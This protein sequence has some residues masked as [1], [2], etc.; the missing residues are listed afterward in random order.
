MWT[1][2]G[3]EQ[4]WTL[5]GGFEA[6]VRAV[7][8][9]VALEDVDGA[10]TTYRELN[11]QANR[12][13]RLLVGRGVG[14]EVR[15]ALVLERSPAQVVAIL[16][17]LK[18]GG[19]Y[20]PIDAGYPPERIALMHADSGASLVLTTSDLAAG[21]PSGTGPL[22]S[23]DEPGTVAALAAHA[24]GNL[25]LELWGDQAVYVI[26]TSGSTGT[27]KGVVVSNANLATL[28]V[29]AQRILR[30][31]PSDVWTLFHSCSFDFAVWEQF[32]ALLH[33]G[34]LVLVSREQA[35]S[36]EEYL[37]LVERAGVT[38]FNQTPSAFLQFVQTADGLG[39]TGWTDP[40]RVVFL[41]GES[42]EAA[43]LAGWYGREPASRPM[44]TNA[45][46]ATEVSILN[47]I[48]LMDPASAAAGAGSLIGTGLPGLGVTVLDAG[49]APVPPGG[50]GEVHV[51]GP[52]VTRGYH[53]RPGLTAR[54]FV[55]DPAGPAGSRMYRTGD[56]A[57]WAGDELEFLGR[58]DDQVK[59]RGFRIELG[60]VEAAIATCPA[61]AQ[62][63]VAAREDRP[64]DQVLVAYV[65][66]DGE[67]AGL[68][69]AV[70]AWSSARLPAHMVPAT[71]LVLPA[72]PLTP[73]GKLDRKAL[74]A[75]PVH[76]AA[77]DGTETGTERAV[78]AIWAQLLGRDG[79]TRLDDFL[80]LGGHSLVAARIAARVRAEL[81]TGVQVRDFY[82]YPRLADFACRVEALQVPAAGT[83]ESE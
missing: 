77:G 41:G 19:A 68:P 1:D 11:A 45:Y 58:A 31:G 55:P 82:D 46:G 63:A 6:Q 59:I 71:V 16:A 35:R 9:A 27:P 49:F 54:S 40:L 74:P 60:E 69:A 44:V 65:V 21:L 78:A 56:L 30:F 33:G 2:Q 81:N 39:R 79:V 43:R 64:G 22:V 23:L 20:V 73:N 50:I 42:L 14:P 5:I 57:R 32:G 10:T 53:G 80:D 29:E 61:V 26:Y 3:R 12:L 51:S 34:R 8:E 52:G 15:V 47:N 28:F 75:P 70:K 48:R 38:V 18:A 76:T 13:A 4:V 17:V 62:S 83:A 7:P 25:D 36:A 72:L 66:P 37:D 24:D 67:A